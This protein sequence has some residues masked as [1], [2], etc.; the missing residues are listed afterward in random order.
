M[1]QKYLVNFVA[2]VYKFSF[3]GFQTFA[4]IACT[5]YILLHKMRTFDFCGLFLVTNGFSHR[6]FL[7]K[8]YCISTVSIFSIMAFQN[9][10]YNHA[11]QS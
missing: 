11:P 8:F 10:I 3:V 6:L 1:S 4:Q 7:L 9:V 2:N 5:E